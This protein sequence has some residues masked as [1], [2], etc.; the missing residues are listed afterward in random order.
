MTE[1]AL[2]GSEAGDPVHI[3]E[4]TAFFYGTLMV[5][6]IFHTVCYRHKDQP[7]TIRA[8]HTFTPAVLHG[9]TRHRVHGADYPGILASPSGSVLGRYVTGLSAAN[10]AALDFFEGSQYERR[11]V[12]V[13][14]LTHVGDPATG[15]GNVEGEARRTAVYVF[16]D[17]EELEE[18]E[19][20]FAEFQRDK[21]HM[22]T[23]AGYAFAEC[24]PEDLA[25]IA[26]DQK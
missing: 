2:S 1:T 24:D 12:T 13:K 3:G 14:L 9:Y 16:R 5:P 23:R 15:A 10:L 17:A 6:D 7:P 25:H 21:M 26:E 19:W 4:H 22:W 18:K 11:T 8:R 20:D